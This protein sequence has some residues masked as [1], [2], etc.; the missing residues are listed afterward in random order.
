MHLPASLSSIKALVDDVARIIAIGA[1]DALTVMVV[2]QVIKTWT[3]RF[4]QTHLPRHQ[5]CL[6]ESFTVAAQRGES[7][8]PQDI[9]RSIMSLR[10]NVTYYTPRLSLWN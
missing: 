8:L 4:D 5:Q 10:A 2:G 6:I 1:S 3:Q 9:E 7:Q